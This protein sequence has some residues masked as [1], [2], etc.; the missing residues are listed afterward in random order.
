[1]NE[2]QSLREEPQRRGE[3]AESSALLGETAWPQTP[4]TLRKPDKTQ[5]VLGTRESLMETSERWLSASRGS[6]HPT[7]QAEQSQNV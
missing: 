6:Q 1:M 4:P 7:A 2:T 5:D 3:M